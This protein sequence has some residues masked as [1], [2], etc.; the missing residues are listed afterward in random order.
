MRE[1]REYSPV[2]AGR[3]MAVIAI[4]FLVMT[5]IIPVMG[6]TVMPANYKVNLIVSNDAGARFDDYSNDS[7]NFFSATQT[8]VMGQNALHLSTNNATPNYGQVTFSSDQSG[9]F[10]MTDTGG[11]GWNDDGI[12]MLAVNGTVPDNFRVHI[13]ASGYQWTPVPADQYP[14][15]QN[16]TYVTGT[17]DEYF[18]S[19]DFLYGPQ[20]W[21]PAP[22]TGNYYPLFDGQDMND[23]A[24]TFSIMFID[25]NAGTLGPNVLSS[26][27][28]SGQTVTDNGA[29][30]IEYSLENLQV[31][32]AFD[33]YAYTVSSNQGQG[34]RW[35]NRLAGAGSSGY[36]VLG[37]PYASHK[38]EFATA[39]GEAQP[40]QNKKS[41]VNS[42]TVP[43]TTTT[44]QSP[45]GAFVCVA[46]LGMIVF[47]RKSDEE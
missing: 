5:G 16:I 21:K 47:L 45:A 37:T 4:L 20:I 38:S 31:L 22:G 30:R 27:T 24:N 8:S 46:A 36:T 1:E 15:C 35:T 33:A 11:R 29:I 25:L 41:A 13:R 19:D 44:Q 43:E 7:Y 26:P 10:Y 14:A 39:T 6:M 12:L 34:I 42:T 23:T 18:T 28:Y 9:V 32:A 3:L 17:L 40:H 2:L